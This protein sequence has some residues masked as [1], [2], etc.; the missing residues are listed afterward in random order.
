MLPGFPPGVFPFW[1]PFPAV[2]PPAAP[3]SAAD[4]P[5]SS[6]EAPQASGKDTYCFLPARKGRKSI[7]SCGCNFPQVAVRPPHQTQTPLLLHRAFPS[8]CLRLLPSPVD[9][10]H[11]CRHFLPLV[12]ATILNVGNDAF[13]C[14]CGYLRLSRPVSSMPPPPPSLNQLSEEEL[15]EMEA[16]GRRG[17]EARLQCLQN[18]HTLLDAAMLNIHHYLSTVTTLT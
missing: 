11:Q 10:G 15:R 5:Q 4:T 8:P 17:L 16:E 2:P 3:P 13:E 18:I 1:G 14:K 6:T 9:R 12:S 7:S